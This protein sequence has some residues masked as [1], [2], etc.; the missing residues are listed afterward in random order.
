LACFK[1]RALSRGLTFTWF[2]FTL[3]WFWSDWNEIGGLAQVLGAG[4]IAASTII[5]IA[6]T[7]AIL[8]SGIMFGKLV[9]DSRMLSSRYVRTA[10][11]TAQVVVLAALYVVLDSPTPEIVYK[12]F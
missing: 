3:L 4:G 10:I 5:M 9:K 11:V 8:T 7:A 1:V 12:A 6:G 2:A